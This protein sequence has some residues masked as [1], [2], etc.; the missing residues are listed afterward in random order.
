MKKFSIKSK[1]QLSKVLEKIEIGINDEYISNSLNDYHQSPKAH[2]VGITGPP[3]VGKSS[4]VNK[5]ILKIRKK[6]LSV[7][8]LAIDPS[9]LKT[10][11]AILG[12][13]ARLDIDPK[14]SKV[15]VRS[16]AAKDYL[17]GISS[18]TF[19]FMVVMRSIFDVVIIETVG[20]GQSEISIQSVADT[21]VY[22]VQPGSGDTLQF[23]KSGVL[24]IPDIVLVTKNDI[25]DLSNT[26]FSDLL[27]SKSF[28]KNNLDWEIKFLSISAI[29]NQGIEEL[30]NLFQERWSWLKNSK[31][32]EKKR[33]TQDQD[34]I[35]KSIIDSFGKEGFKLLKE[36][37]ISFENP[38]KKFFEIKKNFIL[39]F[40]NNG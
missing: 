40:K 17:G 18:L 23:M 39:D 27:S 35:K 21:V 38:F 20:V 13:R 4:L 26:T 7:G 16:M 2:V 30:F 19:P 22:C 34:W 8:V 25:K 5:L 3:G 31:N 12:D 1:L 28:I 32:L 15:F 24:E 37:K 14:D 10:G 9:S 29:K 6:N 11:G 36:R 33:I